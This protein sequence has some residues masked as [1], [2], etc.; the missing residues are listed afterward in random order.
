MGEKRKSK[1][2][3]VF[4]Q[5]IH[6]VVHLKLTQHCESTILQSKLKKKKIECFVCFL[7]ASHTEGVR[8]SGPNLILVH[9]VTQLSR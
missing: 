6:F 9:M 3:W 4:V 7:G 1:E 5:P 8:H 2:E